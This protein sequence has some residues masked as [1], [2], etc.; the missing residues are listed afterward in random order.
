[1]PLLVDDAGQLVERRFFG[2]R[3]RPHRHPSE[4]DAVPLHQLTQILV[5]GDD[6]RDVAFELSG[7]PAVEQVGHAVVLLA[8]EQHDPLGHVGVAQLPLHGEFGCRRPERRPQLVGADPARQTV[9]C[10]LDAQEEHPRGQVAM[11]GRL[12]HGTAEPGQQAGDR[13][14]DAHPVR[15]DDRE[16]VAAHT[17]RSAQASADRTF[18]RRAD[19]YGGPASVRGGRPRPGPCPGAPGQ[20]HPRATASTSTSGPVETTRGARMNTAGRAGP[21]PEPSTR[22]VS[23]DWNWRP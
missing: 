12:E 16:D 9:G 21:S 18:V 19:G 10:D 23:K 17:H 13:G 7:P 6:G 1:M 22:S 3:L 15:A 11:L 4:R 8:G 5:V 14:H 20:A 2:S